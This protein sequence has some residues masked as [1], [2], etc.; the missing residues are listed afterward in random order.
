MSDIK[1]VAGFCCVKPKLIY[2]HKDAE[3]EKLGVRILN[4]LRK[5]DPDEFNYIEEKV[6]A[7]TAVPEYFGVEP[8]RRQKFIRQIPEHLIDHNAITNYELF[9][10]LQGTL[11]P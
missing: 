4:E 1:G 8:Q 3:P 7:L 9:R 10:P 11:E 2:Q 6:S 5:Y